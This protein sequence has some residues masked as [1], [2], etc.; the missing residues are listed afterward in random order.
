VST[1]SRKQPPSRAGR[2]RAGEAAARRHALLDAAFDLLVER[3]YEATTTLA[4]AQRA[5][6]SKETIYAWFGSKAGLFAAMIEA[7][8]AEAGSRIE[9]AL[10]G[11]DRPR[12]T[13]IAFAD[14]LLRLLLSERALALNRAAM[15]SPELAEVLLRHGRHTTGPLVEAYLARLADVGEIAIQDPDDAFRH[16]Y[17]LVVQDSQIRALLGEKPL[18]RAEIKSRATQAVD[19]FLGLSAPC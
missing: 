19:R 1:E 14:G 18:T 10:G 13:L 17:S 8:A 3:G 6:A 5:G 11:R 16:L 12:E 15:T 2:P 7:N 9:A 4:I